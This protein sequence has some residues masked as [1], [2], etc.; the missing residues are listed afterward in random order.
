MMPPVFSIL[1][2]YA[3]VFALVGSRIYRHDDAPQGVQ[4]P[5][6]VWSMVSGMPELQLSGSPLSDMDTVQVDC[7]SETD[8]GVETLAYAVRNAFDNARIANRITL[9]S[10]DSETRLYRISID[11]DIIS[12]RS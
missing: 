11:A 6:I 4:K 5:Y 8:Q 2:N 1:K 3:D 7:L 9:N 12:T 10:R